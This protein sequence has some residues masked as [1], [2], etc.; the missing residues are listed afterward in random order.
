MR[1]HVEVI[2]RKAFYLYSEVIIK[3][4]F[5]CII[6]HLDNIVLFSLLDELFITSWMQSS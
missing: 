3:S 5:I 6:H 4:L 2:V 1:Y